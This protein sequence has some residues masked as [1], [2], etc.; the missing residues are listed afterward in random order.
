MITVHSD[1]LNISNTQTK[2]RNQSTRWFQLLQT[3]QRPTGSHERSPPAP[4]VALMQDLTN[5]RLPEHGYLIFLIT[6]CSSYLNNLDS[7]TVG[8]RFFFFWEEDPHTFRNQ[9]NCPFGLFETHQVGGKNQRR[10]GSYSGQIQKKLRTMTINY[11]YICNRVFDFFWRMVVTSFRTA[12]I[13]GGGLVQ[14]LIPARQCNCGY[15]NFKKPVVVS[16]SHDT[17]RVYPGYPVGMYHGYFF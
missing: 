9:R 14:L 17:Q 8:S 15:Y 11:I 6:V 13:P 10:T 1:H 4:L 3:P 16:C 2:F 12:L 5:A 7:G